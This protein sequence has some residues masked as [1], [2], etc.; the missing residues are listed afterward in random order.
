VTYLRPSGCH[1]AAGRA[2]I[3]VRAGVGLRF[4]H[5][6][7]F[8]E[9]RPPVAW[10][11][12]HPENY[13]G[14]GAPVEA[15][16]DLR[17]D[18]PISFHAT[19]LSLGSA[20]GLDRAH[21]TELAD[22][23]HRIAPAAISDHL[24]W[25]AA[26]GIH[27]PDLLPLPYTEE[28]LCVVARN[29]EAAQARFGRRLLVEN[30]S[31]Y[32]RFA[33]GVLTEAEFLGELARRTGCGVL[34]DVNNVFVSARNLNEDPQAR[35]QAML[36]AIPADAVGEIHLAGHAVQQLPDDA[37]I[38]IDDHGSPVPAGVW[39]MFAE[40]IDAIGP[41]P[42]LIEWDT[43]L[44]PLDTLLGEAAIADT[45]LRPAVAERAYA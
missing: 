28:A 44:P 2:P 22:L 42:T 25:S 32:L 37:D 43:N 35:L 10:L 4:P 8:L 9:E 13:L 20:C 6:R 1:G 7:R 40:V 17:R 36:T 18:Y 15:L 41:R 5:H 29:V 3:L 12:V 21:L 19:G 33:H 27:A 38:L 26:D 11:E 16:A 23:A 30:P 39:A 31:A 34:L 24:S 14:W 45:F